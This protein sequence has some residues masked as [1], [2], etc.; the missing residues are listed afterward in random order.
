M[1]KNIILFDLDGTL[2]NSK[3]GILNSFKFAAK[4]L[5]LPAQSGG[6]LER[7]IGPPIRDTFRECFG[8]DGEAT[9]EAARV[10][11]DYFS[12]Q[13]IFENEL[14]PGIIPMLEKLKAAGKTLAVATSKAELFAERILK[15]FGIDEYFAFLSGGAL[16]GSRMYKL[17]VINHAIENLNACSPDSAVMVGDRKYDILAA[18]EIGMESVGVLYGYGAL[19]ELTE[20]GASYIA[21]DVTELGDLLVSL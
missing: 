21:R 1:K 16:D 20:A 12:R 18:G 3:E 5:G 9:E 8:L 2:T 15:H 7:H 11:R 14:Y 17:D 19:Q 13:G 6:D 4:K 10:Y